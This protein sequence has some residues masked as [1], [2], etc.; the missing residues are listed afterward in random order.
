[1]NT[2]MSH[3]SGC[4]GE[5]HPAFRALVWSHSTVDREMLGEIGRLGERFGAN[6]AG[7]GTHS[8]V[9]L[10]VL[11]HTTGQ[12]KR[13]PAIWTNEGPLAQMRALMTVKRQRFVKGFPTVLAEER[14]VVGVH[15]ALVFPQVRG[16]HKVLAAFLTDV[17]L[18]SCV[19]SDVFAKVRGPNVAFLAKRALVRSFARVQP[20][21][22]L[23]SP[24]V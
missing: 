12:C 11:C 8:A 4:H 1:M 5:C 22:L 21:V 9:N 17:R 13:L 19:R 23:K 24:L 14:L 2:L 15:V 3:Q 7:V 18:L 20:L 6:S 16:T 10:P